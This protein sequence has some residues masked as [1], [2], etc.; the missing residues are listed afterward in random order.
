MF[1]VLLLS[2]CYLT[3]F[4]EFV[5]IGHASSV[6][7][8]LFVHARVWC[9]T[10][11]CVCTCLHVCVWRPTLDTSSVTVHLIGR[12]KVSYFNSELPDVGSV[13][14]SLPKESPPCLLRA[15]LGVAQHLFE[16][17]RSE[18]GSSCL[19]GKPRTLPPLPLFSS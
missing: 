7:P 18:L 4:S 14:I 8:P 10:H 16:C 19:P 11:A 1:Y 2:L 3:D 5:F 12:G 15:G 13:A 9:S 17:W 6:H